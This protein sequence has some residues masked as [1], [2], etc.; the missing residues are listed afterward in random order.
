MPN[1]PRPTS[2]YSSIDR[3]SLVELQKLFKT[4]GIPTIQMQSLRLHHQPSLRRASVR[5]WFETHM[6]YARRTTRIECF[7]SSFAPEV[8]KNC[9]LL[10]PFH[11][12]LYPLKN[13][14]GFLEFPTFASEMEQT[15]SRANSTNDNTGHYENTKEVGFVETSRS[16]LSI[17]VCNPGMLVKA[18]LCGDPKS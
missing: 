6:P 13:P 14:C 7:M 4:T 2:T 17:L 9:E 16:V 11:L 18:H 12:C 1:N 15:H 10:H 5:F 8:V 3:L